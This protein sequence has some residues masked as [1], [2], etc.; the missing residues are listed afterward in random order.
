M[1]RFIVAFSRREPVPASLE[2]ALVDV[3]T[4][5][6]LRL[7]DIAEPSWVEWRRDIG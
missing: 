6:M 4:G 1:H 5:A 3:T 7:G 2:T